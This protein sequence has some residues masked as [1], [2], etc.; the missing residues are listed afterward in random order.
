MVTDTSLSGNLDRVIEI[1]RPS[2]ADPEGDN[3]VYSA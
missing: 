3:I 2:V 1:V